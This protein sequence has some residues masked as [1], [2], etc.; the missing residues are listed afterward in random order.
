MTRFSRFGLPTMPPVQE[1]V[2][3]NP[4]MMSRGVTGEIRL[5][6]PGASCSP[7]SGGAVGW[8]RWMLARKRANHAECPKRCC[9]ACNGVRGLS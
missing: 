7:R 6:A 3:V 4:Q 8:V 1:V 9:S 5:G 2:P